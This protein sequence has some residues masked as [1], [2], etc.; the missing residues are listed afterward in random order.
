MLYLDLPTLEV[1]S[2]LDCNTEQTQQELLERPHSGLIHGFSM[3]VH[4]AAPSGRWAS[5]AFL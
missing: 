4:L 2:K 3:K 5:R 1:Y